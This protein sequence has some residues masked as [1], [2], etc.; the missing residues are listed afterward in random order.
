[1]KM[2]ILIAEDQLQLNRILFERLTKDGYAC[3]QT[4]DGEDCI[5]Y[6]TSTDY[7]L[8]ILDIMMPKKDGLEVLT[9]L[10][11]SAYDIPVILLT[12]KDTLKDKITGLDKGADDYLIKPF[13]YDELLARIRALLRRK[14]KTIQDVIQVSDLIL[15]RTTTEVTR[16]Q[17]VIK[18]SK[19][20]YVILEYL[21]IHA[22]E[23]VSREALERISTTFDYEGYSNVIDVYIRFIRK[24]VDD[25]FEEKLIQTVR[26]FGYMMKEKI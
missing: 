9:Y 24:K 15:N 25:P 14:Q 16:Q 19:K 17:Q 20:E 11:Q 13:S 7:D 8:I 6:V 1:M 3:D 5:N 22:G 2:R 23:T 10:R 12:A 26:G 18:L 4:Y 21:M